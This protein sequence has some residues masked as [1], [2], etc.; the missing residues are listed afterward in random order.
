MEKE[1]YD[2]LIGKE[3]DKYCTPLEVGKAIV[4][5]LNTKF[6]FE[7]FTIYD[8]CHTEYTGPR[9]GYVRTVNKHLCTITFNNNGSVVELATIKFHCKKAGTYNIED[10]SQKKTSEYYAKIS[11]SKKIRDLF[12]KRNLCEILFIRPKI[13]KV[14][15]H[16]LNMIFFLKRN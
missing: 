15:Y 5:E 7:T 1:F 3:F 10:Y 8:E 13:T 6:N 16:K 4:D 12:L 9:F 2:N 11:D 14:K